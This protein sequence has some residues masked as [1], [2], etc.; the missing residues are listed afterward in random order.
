MPV[1]RAT[2][3]AWMGPALADRANLASSFNVAPLVITSST[4]ITCLPVSDLASLN[5]NA[6]RTFSRRSAQVSM[7]CLAVLRIRTIARPA[8]GTS[9]LRPTSAASAAAQPTAPVNRR[10]Q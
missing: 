6:P 2:T 7:P 1:P 3:A 4:R 9:N 10:D 8:T 5:R